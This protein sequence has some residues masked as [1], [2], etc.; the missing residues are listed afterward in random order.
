MVSAVFTFGGRPKDVGW[1]EGIQ[2]VSFFAIDGDR[3]V[4]DRD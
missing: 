4:S 2:D 3:D 1:E